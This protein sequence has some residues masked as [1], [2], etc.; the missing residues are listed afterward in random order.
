MAGLAR[1]QLQPA[2]HGA[3]ART[4]RSSSTATPSARETN[5]RRTN[6]AARVRPLH[7]RLAGLEVH[8]AQVV[9]HVG[10]A[11]H[12]DAQL[13]GR[14]EGV[15]VAE[16]LLSRDV[17]RQLARLL[18]E[19]AL[20]QPA[21]L[22]QPRPRVRRHHRRPLRQEHPLVAEDHGLVERLAQ[23]DRADRAVAAQQPVLPARPGTRADEAALGSLDP[24]APPGPLRAAGHRARAKSRR[25]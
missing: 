23:H 25:P 15:R 19:P 8:R 4:R 9:G 3:R 1:A 7:A 24:G 20:D 21:D 14:H 13:E 5:S 12:A 10:L 6:S 22:E 18:V 17:E 11:V 16:A 2:A